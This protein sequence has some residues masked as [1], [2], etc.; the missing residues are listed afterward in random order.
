MSGSRPLRVLVVD[1]TDHVRD[2]L[3]TMLELDG[4]EVRGCAQGG[5][6]VVAAADEF[7]PHVVVIDYKMPGADGI[8]TARALRA[9]RPE[10]SIVL[11]SAY[12]DRRLEE[13]A[14]A[15]GIALCVGKVEGLM[16]LERQ[17]TEL[18]RDLDPATG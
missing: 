6:A 1:D 16:I 5:A 13:Q 17:L 3:V 7:E 12:L 18:C 2:M 10:Q 9:A 8:A 14:R 11:Y 15:A 4:F